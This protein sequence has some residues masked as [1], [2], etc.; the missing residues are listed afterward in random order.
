MLILRLCVYVKVSDWKESY[1]SKSVVFF[2]SFFFGNLSLDRYLV[3]PGGQV[4][5]N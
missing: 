2:F 3:S 1:M 5:P 4:K